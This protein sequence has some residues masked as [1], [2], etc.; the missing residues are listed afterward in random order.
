[1]T[2]IAMILNLLKTD[3]Q[4]KSQPEN[5]NFISQLES[6]YVSKEEGGGGGVLTLH[7]ICLKVLN[8]LL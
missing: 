6:L 4:K 8:I 7:Q 2:C 1:M 3:G 5:K